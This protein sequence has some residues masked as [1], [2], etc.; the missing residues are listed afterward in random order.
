MIAHR[1]AARSFL[2]LMLG[3]AAAPAVAIGL[4]V[5]WL[6]LPVQFETHWVFEPRSQA[7]QQVAIDARGRI[8][9][10]DDLSESSRV[11]VTF[12]RNDGAT[13]SRT[14]VYAL[15][16]AEFQRQLAGPQTIASW[17][18]EMEIPSSDAPS[19]SEA[20][21]IGQQ[22]MNAAYGGHWPGPPHEP[23]TLRLIAW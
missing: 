19:P 15:D 18:A 3:C 22:I 8:A 16:D 7:F 20:Q 17:M 2:C 21:E 6:Y 23:R 11:T 13:F 10:G 5:V 9:R 1:M 12:V 14:A 4:G